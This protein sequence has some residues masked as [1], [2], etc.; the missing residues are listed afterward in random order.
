MLIL[1]KAKL[2]LD[3]SPKTKFEKGLENFIDWFCSYY[4]Q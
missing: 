4:K 2:M 1:E 3:Y